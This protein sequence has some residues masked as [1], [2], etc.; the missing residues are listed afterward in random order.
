MT[1]ALPKILLS[2]FFTPALFAGNHVITG[3]GNNY[4]AGDNNIYQDNS[5][6][7]TIIKNQPQSKT[8]IHPKKPSRSAIITKSYPNGSVY[9]GQVLN[10]KKHGIGTLTELS[11]AFYTGQWRNDMRNG[12]GHQTYE[13][14]FKLTGEDYNGEWV[15]NRRNGYGSFTYSNNN[16]IVGQWLNDEPSGNCT[17][18]YA[19]GDIF[20]GECSGFNDKRGQVKIHNNDGFFW[21]CIKGDDLQEGFHRYGD[22]RVARLKNGEEIFLMGGDTYNPNPKVACP[23]WPPP[24]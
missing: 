1:T 15:N 21:G 14:S 4:Q 3:S 20:E 9:K 22:G 23:L 10:G 11:R 24:H 16:S 8:K 17:K 7:L 12:H 2:L 6:H 18:Y 13:N 5:K 19:G